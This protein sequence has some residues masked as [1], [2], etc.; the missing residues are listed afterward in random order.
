MSVRLLRR[1]T[2]TALR[3]AFRS[4]PAREGPAF[5]QRSEKRRSRH[6]SPQA[7]H[8]FPSALLSGEDTGNET[9]PPP[10]ASGVCTVYSFYLLKL[11]VKLVLTDPRAFSVC[12]ALRFKPYGLSFRGKKRGFS[13]LFRTGAL[14]RRFACYLF[15][16]QNVLSKKTGLQHTPEPGFFSWSR[17]WGRK[18]SRPFLRVLCAAPYR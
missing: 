1:L 6:P 9:T 14:C 13:V 17:F 15:Q 11:F 8:P 4:P 12:K 3:A 7:P 16:R 18:R 5:S 10:K 2:D